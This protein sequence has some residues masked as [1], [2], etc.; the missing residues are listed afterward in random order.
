MIQGQS[1]IIMTKVSL[2]LM[3]FSL[4][5]CGTTRVGLNFE[6]AKVKKIQIGKTSAADICHLFGEPYRKGIEDGN[7]TWTYLHYQVKIFGGTPTYTKD[8]VVKFDLNDVIY[9]YTYNSN[10]P[11]SELK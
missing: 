6:E 10:W 1:L 3:A 2:L 8:L 11:D 9:S 4:A 7:T 5:S